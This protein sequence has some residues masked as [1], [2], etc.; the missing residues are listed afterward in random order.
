MLPLPAAFKRLMRFII[1]R[2]CREACS[3]PL[4]CIRSPSV[5][6]QTCEMLFAVRGAGFGKIIR[7]LKLMRPCY[8]V[9]ALT[10]G[11]AKWHHK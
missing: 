10:K 11:E 1:S 9:D 2:S 3:Y 5:A 8:N 7:L 6:Q 4:Q